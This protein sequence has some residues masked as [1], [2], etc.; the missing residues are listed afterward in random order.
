[1]TNIS[2]MPRSTRFAIGRDLQSIARPKPA[3]L[4]LWQRLSSQNKGR[5]RKPGPS[6]AEMR[7]ADCKLIS[8]A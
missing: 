5:K 1:M 8:L 6:F 4:E 2:M 7:S 3:L